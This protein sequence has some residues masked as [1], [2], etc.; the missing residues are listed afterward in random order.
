MKKIFIWILV[1]LWM[2]VIFYFSSMDSDAST[3]KSRG[4]ITSTKIIE[5]YEEKKT[6]E[7]KE[8]ILKTTDIIVRKIAHGFEYL[9]LSILVCFLVSEYSLN[10]KKILIISIIVCLLY[11]I[12]DEIHQ[13]YVP[14]RS[15]EL[16]D[17]FIDNIGVSLGLIIFYLSGKKKWKSINN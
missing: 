17:V 5:K 11:S 14:G 7:E 16:M 12:S 2:G 8:E 13:L 15:C 10:I 9:T 3:D 4:I 1:V 6:E